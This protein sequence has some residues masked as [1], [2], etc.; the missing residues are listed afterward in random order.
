MG[1]R[2]TAVERKSLDELQQLLEDVAIREQTDAHLRH[3]ARTRDAAINT[4]KAAKMR[5]GKESLHS[6]TTKQAALKLFRE[7]ADAGNSVKFAEAEVKRQFGVP[8]HTLRE[9]RKQSPAA[10]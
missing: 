6:P 5:A 4:A 3:C 9:W 1:K 2:L 8:P 10:C 7:L